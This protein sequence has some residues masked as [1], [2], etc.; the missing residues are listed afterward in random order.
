MQKY[1]SSGGESKEH[2]NAKFDLSTE[3]HKKRFYQRCTS[4]NCCNGRP[5]KSEANEEIVSAKTEVKVGRWLI[6][7]VYY[8]GNGDIL[9]LIEIKYKNGTDGEKRDW[10]IENYGAKFIEVGTNP[11]PG[12]ND[13]WEIIDFHETYECDNCIKAKKAKAALEAKEAKEAEI[14]QK[15]KEAMKA[16]EAEQYRRYNYD[17]DSI[18]KGLLPKWVR[19]NDE[20]K[21]ERKRWKDSLFNKWF[22]TKDNKH[23]YPSGELKGCH[24]L[25]VLYAYPHSIKYL[26]GKDNNGRNKE[27]QEKYFIFY[28][29][30]LEYCGTEGQKCGTEMYTIE[31]LLPLKANKPSDFTK[32]LAF[33]EKN[34]S[35]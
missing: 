28:K 30:A 33:I 35:R 17:C 23:K 5:I 14:K 31:S 1:S 24:M 10:L 12:L 21:K 9:Y 34:N 13:A 7:V 18:D 26:L 2:M 3:P 22:L 16:R 27:Y 6:D 20:K 8:N 29:K 19:M 4:P 32:I 15:S 25:I 11:I